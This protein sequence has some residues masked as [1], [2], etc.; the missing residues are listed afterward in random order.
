MGG[1]MT[2]VPD[3]LPP[4]IPYD[5]TMYLMDGERDQLGTPEEM[6]RIMPNPNLMIHPYP[7]RESSRGNL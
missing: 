7:T 1:N 2:L 4:D 3:P 5:S 6:G